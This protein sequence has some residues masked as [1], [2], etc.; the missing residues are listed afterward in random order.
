MSSQADIK[1]AV[2][3][4]Y[5]EVVK[6]PYLDDSALKLPPPSGWD[7]VD[8]AALRELGKTDQVVDLLKHLPYLEDESNDTVLVYVE[9]TSVAYHL[10]K[11]TCM[12]EVNP[13][14]GQCAYLTEAH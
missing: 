7:G 8:T 2:T 1:N 6:H 4:F 5:K 14:P 9:T 10:G 12:D 11:M 3:S 13:L